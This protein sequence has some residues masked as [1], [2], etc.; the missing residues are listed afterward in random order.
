MI[1]KTMMAAISEPAFE[2]RSFLTKMSRW[3]LGTCRVLA[4]VNV[5]AKVSNLVLWLAPTFLRVRTLAGLEA[6]SLVLGKFELLARHCKVTDRFH[7][8]MV[9]MLADVWLLCSAFTFV[10]GSFRC[11]EVL[12]ASCVKVG[13]IG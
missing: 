8:F 12:R 7:G 9:A 4:I 10:L 5:F 13:S 1:A 3:P 2:R 6:S 11:R